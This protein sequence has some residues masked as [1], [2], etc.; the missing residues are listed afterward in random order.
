LPGDRDAFARAVEESLPAAQRFARASGRDAAVA[1]G[2]VLAAL[3][4]AIEVLPDPNGSARDEI[5]EVRFESER[6]RR[7]DRMA[8]S[9]P[10]WIKL[11][12]AAALNALEVLTPP[13]HTK[14][15]W[16]KVARQ[17]HEAI[18][19]TTPAT[20]QRALLQDAL[21]TTMTAFVIVGQGLE[22]CQK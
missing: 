15:F 7:S 5:A 19:V 8:F 16:I 21:R 14:T 9:V 13:G 1:A 18:D 20:F 4:H 10:K 3:G 6:L 12:L 17:T 22:V 11:G 2:A